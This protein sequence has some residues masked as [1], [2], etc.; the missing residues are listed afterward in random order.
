MLPFRAQVTIFLR[1][2]TAAVRKTIAAGAQVVTQRSNVNAGG[3]AGHMPTVQDT[4][5]TQFIGA[6]GD[7]IIRSLDETGGAVATVDG[8]VNV[9]P[10]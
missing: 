9:D 10:A 7:A 1:A 8:Y 4:I 2:T 3:T 6:A 5:P